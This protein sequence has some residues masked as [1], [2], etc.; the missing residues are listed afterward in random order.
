VNL[1]K[2]ILLD[3]YQALRKKE[4]VSREKEEKEQ[5]QK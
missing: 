2:P 1:K 5:K 4:K 3:E